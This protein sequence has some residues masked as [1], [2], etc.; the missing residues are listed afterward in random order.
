MDVKE[1][2][3][4]VIVWILLAIGAYLAAWAMLCGKL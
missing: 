4:E 1:V 3:K 2:I